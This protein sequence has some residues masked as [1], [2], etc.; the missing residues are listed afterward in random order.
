MTHTVKASIG[1]ISDHQSHYIGTEIG[2]R[3]QTAIYPR[4]KL[5]KDEFPGLSTDVKLVTITEAL[6]KMGSLSSR[7]QT[8]NAN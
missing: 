2:Y 3:G 7:M 4:P 8:W 1:G 6:T 5:S